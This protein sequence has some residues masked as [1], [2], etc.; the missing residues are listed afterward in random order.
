MSHGVFSLNQEGT[1]ILHPDAVKLEP[2]LKQLTENQLLYVIWVH[3]YLQSPLRKKPIEDRKRLAKV[4]FFPDMEKDLEEYPIMK[5]AILSFKGLI[6]DEKYETADTY[7]NKIYQLQKNL[8]STEGTQEIKNITSAINMLRK[9][10]EDLE[11][12]IED[13][14]QVKYVKGGRSLSMLEQW[15]RNRKLSKKLQGA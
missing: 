5:A 15:Q 11:N 8:M 3:D 4:K 7:K 9:S 12:E 2:V 6:Y 14:E 1:V 13:E 10:I